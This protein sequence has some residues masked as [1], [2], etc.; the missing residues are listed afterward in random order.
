M[1]CSPNGP[2]PK[3]PVPDRRGISSVQSRAERS[4]PPPRF[5]FI[6]WI[7]LGAAALVG[8][9]SAQE[10]GPSL[11]EARVVPVLERHCVS[12]HGPEKQ[13]AEL[14]LDTFAQTMRGSDAGEVVKPGDLKSS[15]LFRRITL[16]TDHE[17]YMPADGK[18]PL[19][20]DEVKILE[21]WIGSGASATAPLSAFP[22]VP[23]LRQARAVA[24]PLAPDWR[25]HRDAIAALERELGVKL[26]PR[27]QVVTDGLVLRT[28]SAPARCE[29]ATLA[30]LAPVA[31]FIVEAQLARTQISDAG[32]AALSTWENLRSLD[33]TRT[34]VT[35]VGLATL[36]QL[37]KIEGI[38][39]TDT[40]VDDAG[41]AQLK[42]ATSLQR[43]WVFGTK[44][45][46]A[47][48]NP[49][50]NAW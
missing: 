42:A 40:A 15:E 26:A 4:V 8:S 48:E 6:G 25:P 13:K 12:C 49:L 36:A 38:N 14:R 3:S 1:A 47:N 2:A 32:L 16:P 45:T 17:E 33:L 27:S 44:V 18:P 11:F 19:T 20:P 46:E 30:R 21:I 22:N 5:R 9:V 34:A 10:T 37:P 43:L 7:G 50:R 24:A 31:A 28:A 23:V 35:S 41:L 39:L 29:D